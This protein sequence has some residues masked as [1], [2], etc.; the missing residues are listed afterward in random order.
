MVKPRG[1]KA[2]ARKG[3]SYVIQ[4]HAA[5]RLHHQLRLE[6][7]GALKKPG[8]GARAE[9]GAGREAPCREVEDHPPRLRRSRGTISKGEYGGRM[10]IVWDRGRWNPIGDPRRAMQRRSRI[11]LMARS[12]AAAGIV[13][14]SRQARKGRELAADQG[15]GCRRADRS[16]PDPRG[17]P[18]SVK[19]GWCGGRSRRR[20]SRVVFEDRQDRT[21]D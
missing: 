9:P 18:E 11:E 19:T 20:V 2:V 14:M 5:R 3:D 7:D 13:R 15:R 16:E 21:G 1:K 6:L 10:V 17:A 4:K 12:S 8:G